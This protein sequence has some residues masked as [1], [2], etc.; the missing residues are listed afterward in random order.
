MAM[1]RSFGGRSLTSSPSIKISPA[2]TS[3]SPAIMRSVVLLPQPEGPTRTQNSLSGISILK[4]ETITWPSIFLVTLRRITLAMERDGALI[5]RVVSLQGSDG[6][7]FFLHAADPRERR[8][9]G[10]QG[11]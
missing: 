2:V 8:A 4:L 7:F 9:R 1:S 5:F 10:R 3:S 6:H 11:R